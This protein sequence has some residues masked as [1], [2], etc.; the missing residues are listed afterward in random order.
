[1][2]IDTAKL[3]KLHS[4][5]KETLDRKSR[6]TI[7][8]SDFKQ[9]ILVKEMQDAPDQR[10]PRMSPKEQTVV[11]KEFQRHPAEGTNNDEVEAYSNDG[12]GKVDDVNYGK[13]EDGESYEDSVA[14]DD[15]ELSEEIEEL[16]E[17]IK[18]ELQ[19]AVRKR[20]DIDLELDD[21]DEIEVEHKTAKEI[22]KNSKTRDLMKASKNKKE[23]LKFLDKVLD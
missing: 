13:A 12:A 19:Q 9:R 15:D 16:H 17:N 23:F 14:E 1:M 11:N 3:G 8:D 4:S 5:I 6:E 7:T 21:G 10:V 22:L 18:R 2:N 20:Q